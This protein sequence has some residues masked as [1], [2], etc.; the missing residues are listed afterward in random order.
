MPR[1]TQTVPRYR[2]H[3]ASGQAFVEINGRR[4]YLGPWRSKFG[5]P[6]HIVSVVELIVGYL[7]YAK[8]YYGDGKRGEY[9]N[10]VHALRP[11][12]ELYGRTA[13][14]EFG[15]LNLKA[16]RE[17]F[18]ALG[19]SRKHINQ[20]V[21]RIGRVFRW[22]VSEG[23]IPPEVPQAM[24]MV[25]GLRKG[26]TT[27]RE[28]RKVRPVDDK[29]VDATLPYLPP[30]VRSMV[31]LQRATGMRPGEVVILRPCDVDRSGDVWEYRPVEHKTANR[32][33]DRII[34]IGPR[35]QA[36]LRQ[37]L[38]RDTEA[39]C[40]SPRDSEA[41]RLADRHEA[42]KVPLSCGNR[43]GT[44]RVR[45]KPQRRAGQRYTP[46]SYLYAVRRACDKAFP[47]PADIADDAAAVE[48]WHR[49]HRWSPNRLR[50]AL[51]TK[52]RREFDIESAKVLLGHSQ[53]NMSGHY[54]EQDRRR[55]IEVA[56]KIG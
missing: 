39:F 9:A 2:K 14:R 47:V 31:E 20:N 25:P 28:G 42:R 33:Q 26:H 36:V 24:A 44:N 8:K 12:R 34:Y 56:K 27:A 18:I 51:A 17:K 1:L 4:H 49:D 6:E 13:A 11:L 19:W 16:V 3:R 35:G 29:L 41:K 37:Y 48:K 53:I 50:H 55:A 52:V 21:Q 45:H 30:V 40:F 23:M 43:P 22:A 10:M 5:V 38:L 46:Q 54:A 32:D 15:P 7:E